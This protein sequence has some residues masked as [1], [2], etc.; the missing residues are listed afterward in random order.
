MYAR[1]GGWR[2]RDFVAGRASHILDVIMLYKR[3]RRKE[4][5]REYCQ[6]GALIL[7]EELGLVAAG[8][9][10]IDGADKRDRYQNG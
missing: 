6:W 8:L 5:L 10:E 9:G 2:R 7:A 4:F 1:R 3:L